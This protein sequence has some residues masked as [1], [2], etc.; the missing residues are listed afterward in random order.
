MGEPEAHTRDIP[1]ETFSGQL[2]RIG[3]RLHWR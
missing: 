3:Q 1:E 2:T